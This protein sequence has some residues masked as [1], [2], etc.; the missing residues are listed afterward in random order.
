M[1]ELSCRPGELY[2]PLLLVCE[3]QDQLARIWISSSVEVT[4]TRNSQDLLIEQF[5]H[6]PGLT[7][8]QR[9]MCEKNHWKHSDHF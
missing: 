4:C 6:N 5:C 2:N 7:E 3:E 1:E 9:E 8:V